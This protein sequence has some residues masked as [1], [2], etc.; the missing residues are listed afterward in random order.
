MQIEKLSNA[1]DAK[2]LLQTLGVDGGGISI[3]QSK[4]QQHILYIREL[5][6]GAANIL[7]QD[8]LSIG[9][10]L[11]VP[12]GTVIA[13]TPYVDCILIATQKQL[14]L[15]SKKELAQPF[16]LKELAQELQE[17]VKIH[18]P[19]HVEIMGIINANDDSFYSASRF[20]GSKAIE[21]I[22]QMISDGAS[23]ID[24]GGVSSRPNSLKVSADEELERVKPIIDMLSQEK[25][26]TKAQFSIDSYEPKVIAYAL[27][28]GFKIINDITGLQSDE[29]CRLCAEY[30][31]T[32]VIMHM[33]G[34]PQ[35]MQDSPHYENILSD[36]Y[37]FF[38]ERVSKAESFGIKEIVLDVG[39]GFGKRLQDNLMLIKHLENFLRLKKPLLV[40]A[41]RKSLIDTISPSTIE[42]RLAGTLAL[43]LES[44]QNGASILR[45]HDVKEHV[46]AIKIKEALSRV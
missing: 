29:V 5:H 36:V 1:V 9:A 41:S 34:E 8:A 26:S 44:A 27:E 17:I 45:V 6:V 43:H 40:G 33:Q 42:E 20:H 12:R 21:S 30:G 10:D 19:W 16:G 13:K 38:Q 46:Q 14:Q 15:L 23:I 11:A 18:K 7:K 39:I 37:T 32:A 3:L 31:A 22:E 24:I 25:L 2:K 4:M 28:N 35:T